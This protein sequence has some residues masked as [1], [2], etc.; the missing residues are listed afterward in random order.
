[1]IV[2]IYFRMPQTYKKKTDGPI[3]GTENLKLALESVRNGL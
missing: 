1:M 2:L 3:Y